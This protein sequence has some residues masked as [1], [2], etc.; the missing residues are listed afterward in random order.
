MLEVPITCIQNGDNV[1]TIETNRKYNPGF[2]GVKMDSLLHFFIISYP[3]MVNT[4]IE[5]AIHNY[6]NN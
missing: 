6:L 3:E 2:T 5:F 4:Q 1:I